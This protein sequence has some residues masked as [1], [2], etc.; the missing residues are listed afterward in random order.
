M[1]DEATVESL[2]AANERFYRT[3]EALDYAA[4]DALWEHSDRVF[5]V[6]P[7]WPPLHGAKPVL[8]SWWRIIGNTTS[9][10]F[11]LTGVEA[12]VEGHLGIVTVF[13]NIRSAVSDETHTSGTI[14]TNMFA[15]DPQEEA[16]KLFH[17]HA[18]PTALPTGEIDS[19]L[20]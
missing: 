16:W 8:E 15:F 20:N 18:S 17:H 3:F 2:V 9:I 14:S 4:M 13:E 11:T 6:H 10:H 7:G 19:P 5:C 1:T 12:R